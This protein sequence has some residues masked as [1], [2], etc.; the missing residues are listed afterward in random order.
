MNGQRSRAEN[1]RRIARKRKIKKAVKEVA[2][3][4]LI[5]G[6]LGGM[7]I[8]AFINDPYEPP[9]PPEHFGQIEYGGV[10]WDPED[11]EQMMIER[12]Q[13]LKE[14]QAQEQEFIN[15]VRNVQT[16][17]EA[18]AETTSQTLIGSRDWD[19]E[20]SYM[21]GKIAM[22]EAEGEDTE[23][24]ALVILVVLNRVWSDGFP[25]SIEEVITEPGQF[26]P[27]TEGGRYYTTEPDEDCWAALSMVMHGWDESQGATYFTSSKEQDTWHSR[28]LTKLFEH[29]N[30]TFYK[31]G[32]EA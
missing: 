9:K 3:S 8:W 13:Y 26:S 20:E 29:G 1:R 17:Q 18:A 4:M 27:V 6:L 19:A 2:G 15:A 24:K 16:Q 28:N 12:E 30:H 23:G 21:L 25:D 11:Y 7:L 31:E 5:G 14:E 32:Q 22:A 10:W